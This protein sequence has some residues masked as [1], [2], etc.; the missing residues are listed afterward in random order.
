MQSEALGL[1]KRYKYL[2]TAL[3]K[4]K[5]KRAGYHPNSRPLR[6]NGAGHAH[7][8]AAPSQDVVVAEHPDDRCAL[9]KRIYFV[10]CTRG[11]NRRV[12]HHR[13]TGQAA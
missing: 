13:R 3:T 6:K 4:P 11:I 2:N 8:K 1:D 7:G 10:C 9:R 12:F 5:Q